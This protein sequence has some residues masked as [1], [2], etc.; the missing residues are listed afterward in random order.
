[1]SR[2]TREQDIQPR[3]YVRSS[4]ASGEA[5]KGDLWVDIV[6]AKIYVYTG[7]AWVQITSGA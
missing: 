5:N 3:I 6:N 2:P 7:T 1:M 4:A